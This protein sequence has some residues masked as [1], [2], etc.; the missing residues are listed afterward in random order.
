MFDLSGKS[1]LVTGGSR[2]LGRAIVKDLATAGAQ[3]SFCYRRDSASAET[4]AEEVEGCTGRRPLVIQADITI[5]VDRQRLVEHTAAQLGG[6][7]ILVNNAGTREDGV[8]LRMD[9]AWDHVL[10]LDL[11]APF[12]LSQLVLRLMIRQSWGRII[13]I[14]SIASRIGLGGQANYTAAKAGLEGL[15]RSLA[16]EYGK[17]GITVNTLNPGFIETDLTEDASSQLREALLV[18]AAIPRSLSPEA[19]AGAVVFLASEEAW[20]ITGQAINVDCGLVKL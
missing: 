3:V 8:A 17:R 14:G 15:T 2:G 12:R 9:D 20:A 5:G 7:D 4:V 6:I 1:A 16:Q 11:T 10:D 19:V 13:N 18:R